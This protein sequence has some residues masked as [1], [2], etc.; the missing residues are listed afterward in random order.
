MGALQLHAGEATR[1]LSVPGLRATL[2]REHAALEGCLERL[3][4]ATRANAS[5]ELAAPWAELEHTLTHHLVF[6]E[7]VLFPELRARHPAEVDALLKE[8]D[9]LRQH[10]SELGIEIDLHVARHARVQELAFAL[11]THAAREDALLYR[12]AE[13][14]LSGDARSIANRRVRFPR[15]PRR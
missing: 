15:L 6:E 5:S 9:A 12:Q 3:L 11:R 4:A 10:V 14:H 2:V 7:L 1:T 13:A 8:H